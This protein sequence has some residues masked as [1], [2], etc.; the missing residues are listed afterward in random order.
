MSF[1]QAYSAPPPPPPRP[2][3]RGSQRAINLPRAVG[4]LLVANVGIYVVVAAIPWSWEIWTI[5]NLGFVPAKY[6]VAG[7]FDWTAL[8]APLSHQFLHG[9]VVH[10]LVNM[11]MLAAFGSGV[12]RVLGTRRMLF[13][14]FISG[15]AGGFAHWLFYPV[16]TVP[17]VGAS[18]AIS[19]LFGAVLRLM[20]LRGGAG[21]FL[22]I[23]PVAVIW[24]GI[25]V[26]VGFT[27]MPGTG[28]AQIAW[29]AHIGGFLVGLLFFDLFTIGLRRRRP[30]E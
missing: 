23:L 19:G 18:G 25:S 6:S 14:Y 13:L 8:A 16:S 1:N 21:G 9:G 27:G 30:R 17:V 2:P 12:E 24:I 20:A 29:A 4:W 3:N 7:A 22:R 5:L 11:V 10:L 28:E 15:I 26:V